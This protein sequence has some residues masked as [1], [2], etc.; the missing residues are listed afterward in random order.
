MREHADHFPHR[1]SH[2]PPRPGAQDGTSTSRWRRWSWHHIINNCLNCI[3]VCSY[4]LPTLLFFV[5][6]NARQGYSTC[7]TPSS[8]LGTITMTTIIIRTRLLL[9]SVPSQAA[10]YQRRRRRR[11]R[12]RGRPKRRAAWLESS[13]PPPPSSCQYSPDPWSRPV[14][15]ASSMPCAYQRR[16]ACC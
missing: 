13:P 6:A 5:L 14:S 4:P 2:P 7:N 16:L 8:T 3:G 1:D 9:T 12:R 15:P 11:Q 10:Q